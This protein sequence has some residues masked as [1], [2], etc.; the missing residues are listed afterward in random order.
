MMRS[1]DFHGVAEFNLKSE[2]EV[3]GLG[4]LTYEF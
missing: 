4:S 3:T 1:K 2:A